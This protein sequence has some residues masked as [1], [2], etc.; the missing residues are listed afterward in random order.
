MK[1]LKTL[2]ISLIL[3][4]I[5]QTLG[6][7][8]SLK[9]TLHKKDSVNFFCFDNRQITFIRKEL[10]LKNLFSDKIDLQFE[11]IKNLQERNI[12]LETQFGL[13]QKIDKNKNT[14]IKLQNQKLKLQN[15]TIENLNAEIKK[16]KRIKSKLFVVL[17][18]FSSFFIY[19][20]TK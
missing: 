14:E 19:Q 10:E 20:L 12:F 1:K 18:I 16:E 6:F 17:G 15:N 9:P 13:Y 8:Q 5:L 11:Q 3:Y 7:S 2:I 4:L